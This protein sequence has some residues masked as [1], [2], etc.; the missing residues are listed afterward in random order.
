MK[1]ELE[2]KLVDKYPKLFAQYGKNPKDSCMAWGCDCDDGWYNILDKLFQIISKYKKVE[3]AQVKEK[4]GTLR[5]YV[6][7]P[8]E[9]FNEVH[10][11]INVAEKKSSQ[12]CEICGNPGKRNTEM[13][14]IKTVCET[15][16]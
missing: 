5:V 6:D 2:K 9:D 14:F 15:C 4:F 10:E 11:Y 13:G 7:A 8:S 1:K 3:L 12:T 16:K